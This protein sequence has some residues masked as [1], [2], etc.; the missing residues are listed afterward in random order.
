MLYFSI[1]YKIDLHFS[2]RIGFIY[3]ED[4]KKKGWRISSP[5]KKMWVYVLKKLISSL[6]SSSSLQLSS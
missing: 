4:R 3:E 2:R 1:G 5:A 6:R